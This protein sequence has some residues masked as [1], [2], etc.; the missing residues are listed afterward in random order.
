MMKSG[1]DPTALWA[2]TLQAIA[3]TV[4]HDLRNALNAVAVNLEVVRGR[5]AR[6]AEPSSIAPFAAT[7]ATTFEGAAAA[8]EALLAFARS[9]PGEADVAAIAN[10]LARLFAVGSRVLTVADRSGGRART[11]VP[12][13][14]VRAALARSVLT[15][16]TAGDRVACE[17]A[18]DD[19]IFLSVTGATSV[20]PLPD[21]SFVDAAAAYGVRFATRTQSLELH[22]PQSSNATSPRSS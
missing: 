21:A 18:V 4:A 3:A 2:E 19:G 17:I 22:F 13:D 12:A 8:A 7:A 14:I 10:R 1:S 20:P 5:S 15:A 9:E 11:G 16:F 6:G